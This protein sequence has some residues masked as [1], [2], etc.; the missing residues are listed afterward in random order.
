MY[1]HV[2]HCGHS[3]TVYTRTQST[4]KQPE[5]PADNPNFQGLKCLGEELQGM[6][7]YQ[8]ILPS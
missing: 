4:T 5:F 8:Y 7:E 6:A 2:V 1:K 3:V